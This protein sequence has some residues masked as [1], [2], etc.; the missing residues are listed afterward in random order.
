VKVLFDTHVVLD[1]LLA[2]A[3][4]AEAAARLF[5]LVD[6]RR[7]EGAICATTVTTVFYLAGKAVGV[8][9]ARR[10]VAEL[11][12]LFSVAAVGRS[13]LENAL[14][15][16]FDDFEDA[17]LHEA[18]RSAGMTAIVTRNGRDFTRATLPV[19]APQELLAALGAAQL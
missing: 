8:K 12:A 18:A 10:L 11:L 1:V 2:R 6:S 9:E 19:F 5:S 3:P 13:E 16:S 4:H 7:L 15:S 17:V 14:A